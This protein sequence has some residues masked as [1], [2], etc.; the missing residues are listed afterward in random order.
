MQ[1]NPRGMAATHGR[2]DVLGAHQCGTAEEQPEGAGHL[3]GLQGGQ[4]QRTEGDEVA[5]A[6]QDHPR[7]REHQNDGQRDQRINCAR[8]QPVLR[9]KGQDCKVHGKPQRMEA[10]GQS[11]GDTAK[12]WQCDSRRRGCRHC[13][14]RGRL[15]GAHRAG[16]WS[17]RGMCFSIDVIFFICRATCGK[18]SKARHRTCEERLLISR[19]HIRMCI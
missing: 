3:P 1:R 8:S 10:A 18:A 2:H 6:D 14:E 19:I 13:G 17:C 5:L 15:R 11:A 9:Q 4:G 12:A 16:D 7:Y